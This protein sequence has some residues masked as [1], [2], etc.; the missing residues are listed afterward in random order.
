MNLTKAIA[1]ARALGGSSGSGGGA[2]VVKMTSGSVSFAEN[3]DVTYPN[4]Y[5][6]EH[7]LGALPDLIF[8]TQDAHTP[9]EGSN[10]LVSGVLYRISDDGTYRY[11]VYKGSSKGR[12][13]IKSGSVGAPTEDVF[14]MGHIN[15]ASATTMYPNHSYIWYA[16]KWEE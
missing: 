9:T 4:Y 3:F 16:F 6:V 10:Y 2:G 8:F 1:I 11:Q 14:Y 13:S 7:G 5:A 12:N 15:N